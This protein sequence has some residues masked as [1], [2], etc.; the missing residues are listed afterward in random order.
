[1]GRQPDLTPCTRLCRHCDRPIYLRASGSGQLPAE[2]GMWV[3][4]DPGGGWWRDCRSAVGDKLATVAD[5]GPEPDLEVT[6]LLHR[7][8]AET[9]QVRDS[10]GTDW[11]LY[12][13]PPGW[14]A[15]KL[16]LTVVEGTWL[17]R[18]DTTIAEP[19]LP[20]AGVI[21]APMHPLGEP[22]ELI[23]SMT[24]DVAEAMRYALKVAGKY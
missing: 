1:M 13:A 11:T 17:P 7:G 21:G 15:W 9:W 6:R 2:D 23:D 19:N 4:P 16:Q 18:L 20:P 8:A 5:P 24:P 3:H 22:Y 14:M 10:E 12:R